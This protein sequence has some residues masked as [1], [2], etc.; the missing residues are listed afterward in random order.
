M[1]ITW[2]G[3]ASVLIETDQAQILF[4]PYLKDL[5]AGR[6]SAEAFACRKDRFRQVDQILITHGHFDHLSSVC[7]LYREL[8]CTVSLSESPAQ[9]LLPQGFPSE[10]L[11]RIGHGNRLEFGDLTVLVYQGKHV[12]FDLGTARQLFSRIR[13]REQAARLLR[14]ARLHLHYPEKKETLFFEIQAEGKRIQLMGSAELAEGVDYPTGAD[15]LILAHQGRSDMDRHN[16]LVVQKLQPKR[17]LLDHYDDAFP[18]ISTAVP[19]ASF[20]QEMSQI[21]PTEVLAEG[22]PV[23]L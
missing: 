19:T 20:C 11:R 6:E 14:M 5:P 16:R 21:V 3:T 22:V 8:P 4:D 1:K 13:T 9:N 7:A 23:V 2:F 12:R 17:V 18:P 10:K 15:V